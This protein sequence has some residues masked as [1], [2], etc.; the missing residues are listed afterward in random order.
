MIAEIP[1]TYSEWNDI[2]KLTIE[3]K[4]RRKTSFPVRYIRKI[5]K[6]THTRIRDIMK[7]VGDRGFWNGIVILLP[8]QGLNV[9]FLNKK[10]FFD[11]DLKLSHCQIYTNLMFIKNLVQL[12]DTALYHFEQKRIAFGY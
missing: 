9:S 5:K 3:K 10:Q 11:Q 4:G 8:W 6:I 2:E 12:E 1:W 7:K